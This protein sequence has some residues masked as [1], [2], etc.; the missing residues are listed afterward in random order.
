[1]LE[2]PLFDDLNQHTGQLDLSHEDIAK[3]AGVSRAS[4]WRALVQLRDLGILAWL[5]RCVGK[6]KG[7]R[8]VLAQ[9]RNM[10][11]GGG[12]DP[13]GNTISSSD[14]RGIDVM[15]I[16]LRH[17]CRGMAD[18]RR[19]GD[20]RHPQIRG[21]AGIWRPTSTGIRP[22]SETAYLVR[23]LVNLYEAMA[24]RSENRSNSLKNQWRPVGDSNPCYRRERA[25]S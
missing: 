11:A 7:S 21:H 20:F 16:P 9:E 14:K 15:D 6:L 5:R 8:Y 12:G 24:S 10:C 1:M 19:N 25:A 13:R 3:K 4:L 23:F 22:R 2:C 18:Q 17:G